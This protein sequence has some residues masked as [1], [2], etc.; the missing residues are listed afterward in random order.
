MVVHRV[1]QRAAAALIASLCACAACAQSYPSRPVRIVAGSAAGTTL[2][3]DATSGWSADA[4]AGGGPAGPGEVDLLV[5]HGESGAVGDTT[6][7]DGEPV[8]RIVTAALPVPVRSRSGLLAWLRSVLPR[9]IV[10]RD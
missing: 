1:S 10:W 5:L 6:V 3:I 9:R 8:R 4:S 7:P 2:G